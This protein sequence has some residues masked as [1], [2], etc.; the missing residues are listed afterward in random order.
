MGSV[1]RELFKDEIEGEL[2]KAQDRGEANVVAKMYKNGFTPA[3]IAS[4]LDKTLEE[5]NAILA[6]KTNQ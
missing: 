6:S 4:A 1:L 3:Q 5:V 2:K